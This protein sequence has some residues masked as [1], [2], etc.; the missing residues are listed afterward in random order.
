MSFGAFAFGDPAKPRRPRRSL[1]ALRDV[2]F[3][4]TFRFG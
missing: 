3:A 1:R 2:H 4:Q